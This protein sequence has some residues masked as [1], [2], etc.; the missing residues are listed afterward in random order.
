MLRDKQVCT[1]TMN[2]FGEK[3]IEQSKQTNNFRKVKVLFDN[4]GCCILEDAHD[5]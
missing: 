3:K 4:N 5:V 1:V 2:V